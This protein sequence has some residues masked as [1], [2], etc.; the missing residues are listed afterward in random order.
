LD[1]IVQLENTDADTLSYVQTLSEDKKRSIG[2]SIISVVTRLA[3][4]FK[5]EE[6]YLIKIT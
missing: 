3:L 6:V 2:I 5:V 4:E 1:D